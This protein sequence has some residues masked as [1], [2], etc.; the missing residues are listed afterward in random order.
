M[1]VVE[2]NIDA[3]DV[4]TADEAFMT[5]TPFCMLPVTSPTELPSVPEMWAMNQPPF[6]SVEREH[7]RRHRQPDQA[8]GQRTG[9]FRLSRCSNPV[10]L[11]EQVMHQIGFMQGRLCDQVGAK[12]KP[13]VACVEEEFCRNGAWDPRHGMDAGSGMLAQNPLMTAE[14]RARIHGLQVEYPIAIPSLTGDCFM[15]APF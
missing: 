8:V 1:P 11:Q 3:Y 4:Y 6:E 12:S 5:G 14:G 10:S 2:R 15:Q 9:W 7:R 13:S